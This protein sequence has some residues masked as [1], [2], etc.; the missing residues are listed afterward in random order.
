MTA[1]ATG[2]REM[3]KAY[4]PRAVERRLYELW[5]SRGYFTPVLTRPGEPPPSYGIAADRN[6]QP[7]TIIM[8]PPNVT[9]ELHLGHAL[10]DTIEDT[11]I[12]WRRMLGDPTLWLPGTDHAGIAT[13]MVVE[14]EL[15]KEGLTR[16]DLGREVFVERVWQ[17]VHRYRGRID[18]Q[19]RRLGASADWSR[20]RFTLDPAPQ[21]AVR[22]TFKRLYDDGLIYR[23]ERLI[24]WCPRCMT[25]LSDLEVDRGDPEQGFIWHVKYPVID[26]DGRETG[27]YIQM[28]TTRPETILGDTGVAVN[29][30]DER[31]TH[32]VG[33]RAR[34]PIIGRE[35]PIV[36][37]AAVDPAFGTGAVKVTPGHDPTDYD[38]GARHNLPIVSVM[39]QDATMNDNAGPFAGLDRF[40]ARREVIKAFEGADLLV[41][42]EPHELVIGRCDRCNTIVEPMVSL[43]W[44]VRMQTLAEPAI[45]A[46]R[47]GRIQ[48][49]PEAFERVYYNWM[50]NIRDWCISRQL[51]WGHRIP[52]W[53]CDGCDAT[54]VEVETPTSCP[55][56]CEGTP[57]QD[58][59]VL[60]TWFSSGLWPFSTLGWPRGSEDLD[61]FYPTSVMETGYDILFFWVA[62]M[63][64]LGMYD[65]N[66]AVPFRHV[67]LHG[68]MRDAKGVKFSKTK[69]NATD[70]LDL[71]DQYGADALRFTL[72]TNSSPGIDM[73]LQTSDL[74]NGRNFANKL[75]NTAR[76]VLSVV[77]D[78]AGGNDGRLAGPAASIEDRWILSRLNT[79]ALD[80]NRLLADFQIGEAGRRIYDFVWHEYADWYI[81][82]AKVRLRRDD[83]TA[84]PVLTHVLGQV[85]SLLHPFMPFVTEEIWQNVRGVLGP[86]TPEV[87][88]IA[89]YPLG[90]ASARDDDAERH[91][92][93][94]MDTVRAVRNL[95]AE[96]KIDPARP[97]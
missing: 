49:I 45:A 25:A 15:A 46:V 93:A 26:D 70:P 28:A 74:E 42:V 55:S 62:R 65:M 2:R 18:D 6:R 21:E 34:L 19:H 76:F 43:Q 89:A 39:N 71:V 57:R 87:V 40:E 66:G 75:W 69:G 23:G 78:E 24:T 73:K 68:M 63:I 61:Y 82:M 96:R 72:A 85:L 44:F 56:G 84:L 20:S 4:D 35:I 88:T 92:E 67:Y 11:L 83:R 31:Y 10:T 16:H 50:E 38:I 27:E 7:F 54:L 51:W 47:D 12:R 37:D 80:V 94:L 17:W 32:L 77:G 22:T 29:P 86:E 41:K 95:R 97:I 30:D 58:E 1:Q 64:M 48:I 3:P 59:D 79:L 8:P 90:D 14:R 13:Q 5:E 81:E 33:R 91:T 36:A 60:D 9:G 53:Y 52:V